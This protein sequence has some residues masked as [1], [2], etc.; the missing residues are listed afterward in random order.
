MGEWEKMWSIKC[1]LRETWKDK[2]TDNNN[3]TLCG[4]L[5]CVHA[6]CKRRRQ[7]MWGRRSTFADL[8]AFPTS[9]CS[10]AKRQRPSPDRNSRWSVAVSHRRHAVLLQTA[11]VCPNPFFRKKKKNW[12]TSTPRL[13]GLDNERRK[14]LL[15]KSIFTSWAEGTVGT[16]ENDGLFSFK[17]DWSQLNCSPAGL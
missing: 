11:R 2:H 9:W 4:W 3:R 8:P 13:Q 12:V 16:F 6:T 15:V 5:R 17:I 7:A 14:L 10:G 1:W